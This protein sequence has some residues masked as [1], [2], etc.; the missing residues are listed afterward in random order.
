MEKIKTAVIGAGNMGVNHMRVYK[1]LPHMC[2]LVG[3]YDTDS[4]RCAQA[5][6]KYDVTA[7][8][9]PG[10]LLAQAEAVSVAV[11]TVRH[12]D[13]AWQALDMGVHVLLEKPVAETAAQGEELTQLAVLNDLVL[14]I[15]HVER[16]NPAV[17]V[18]PDILAGKEIIGLDFRRMS[19]YDPR[20]RDVGVVHDLMIHDIDVLRFLIPTEI[21][22]LH[23]Y[24]SSPRSGG[25]TDYAAASL[26]LQGGAVA[27]ITASRVT[28]QK[29]RTLTVTTDQAY[30]E[31]DYIDR[32]I[33][34]AR[35]TQGQF[36]DGGKSSYRQENI[37]EKVFVPNQEP[38]MKEIEAFLGCVENGTPPEI[39]GEDGV[40]ALVIAN[41]IEACVRQH[42]SILV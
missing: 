41:R 42:T 9:N 23:A 27:T 8:A 17:Q 38:L 14:Q 36:I 5:A 21:M 33:T 18:M 7:Y 24:G 32:K 20:I 30:V 2:E 40:A 37:I 4:D 35:A 39:G 26:L 13:V 1:A 11:P 19:P 28:E 16:F 34:V 6:R 31:L 15:G 10:D 3:V 29:V 22:D 12:Y 25:H